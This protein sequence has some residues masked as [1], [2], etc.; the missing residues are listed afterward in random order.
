MICKLLKTVSLVA[1][2]L[3]PNHGCAM[4]F[5]NRRTPPPLLRRSA[6]TMAES[7]YAHLAGWSGREGAAKKLYEI[8]EPDVSIYYLFDPETKHPSHYEGEWR[9]DLH[10]SRW[11]ATVYPVRRAFMSGKTYE[12]WVL[13]YAGAGLPWYDRLR[14]HHYFLG[15]EADS[16]THKRKIISRSAEVPGRPDPNWIKAIVLPNGQELTLPVIPRVQQRN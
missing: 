14:E 10:Q 8:L 3:G 2:V 6:E 11:H 16:A 4:M 15:T 7:M 13:C 9:L 1:L 5:P 12:L